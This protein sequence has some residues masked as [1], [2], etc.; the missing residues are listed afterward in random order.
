M[1]FTGGE[2]TPSTMTAVNPLPT[3][4]T[5]CYDDNKTYVIGEKIKRGCNEQCKCGEGGKIT[6]CEPLTCK[7]PYVKADLKKDDNNCQ[8]HVLANN[9]CCAEV[10]CID[11]GELLL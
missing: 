9:P 2:F 6:S 8:M 1:I 7:Y 3:V 10:V 11:S 5:M 4:G